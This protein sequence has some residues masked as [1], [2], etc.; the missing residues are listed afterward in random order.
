MKRY[1]IYQ[2]IAKVYTSRCYIKLLA[3]LL[4]DLFFGDSDP[5]TISELA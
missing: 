2:A 1:Y 5:S 4:D 3:D